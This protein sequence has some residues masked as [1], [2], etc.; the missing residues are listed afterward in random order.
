MSKL[1][2]LEYTALSVGMARD[3]ARQAAGTTWPAPDVSESG[4]LDYE[5]TSADYAMITLLARLVVIGGGRCYLNARDGT[6]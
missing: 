1:W 6:S 3:I 5:V 2:T 4:R